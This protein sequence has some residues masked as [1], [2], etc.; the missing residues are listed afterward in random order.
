VRSTS[1]AVNL[2]RI[3]Q[4]WGSRDPAFLYIRFAHEMNLNSIKWH[5]RRGEEKSFVKAITQYSTLRYKI[6]PQAQIVLCPNDG[7]ETGIDVRTLWP[8]ADSAG[9]PVANVY[10][11]DS[12]NMN[13]H[14]TTAAEFTKKINGQYSDGRPLGI[15]KHREFAQSVGVPFA[16][17]EWGNNGDPGNPGGGGE[18]PLYIRSFY[19]WAA[20]HA[21]DID[22][23]TAGQLLYEV[24]FNLWGQYA[25]WPRTVQP[26]TAAAYRALAWGTIPG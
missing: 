16:I 9:R 24:H 22:H 11:V 3:K 17:G 20:S 6:L 5:V 8:G 10:A 4:C 15:E 7:T 1:P 13:P 14:V 25:F 23:P 19:A 2:T 12:Y 26:R 21:G 18:S